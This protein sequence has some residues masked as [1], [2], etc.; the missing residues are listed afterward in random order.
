MGIATFNCSS[1]HSL[2]PLEFKQ[3]FDE[4]IV[5][6]LLDGFGGVPTND[7][8]RLNITAATARV[9]ITAPSPIFTPGMMIASDPIHMSFLVT[10]SP[11]DLKPFSAPV[12][13]GSS[14]I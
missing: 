7:G 13:I 2:P 4:P 10:V 14:D 3:E 9:P 12:N 11:A 6:S 8:I 5:K 1:V